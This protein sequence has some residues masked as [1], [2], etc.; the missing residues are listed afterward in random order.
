MSA[1]LKFIHGGV[2]A[3]IQ[4]LPVLAVGPIVVMVNPVTIPFKNILQSAFDGNTYI[5]NMTN[6][7]LHHIATKN[8]PANVAARQITPPSPVQPDVTCTIGSPQSSIKRRLSRKAGIRCLRTLAKEDELRQ[9]AEA[10]GLL[11]L[12]QWTNFAFVEY[13]GATAIEEM[14]ADDAIDMQEARLS[15]EKDMMSRNVDQVTDLLTE[16]LADLSLEDTYDNDED[17]AITDLSNILSHMSLE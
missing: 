13:R 6:V 14:M 2:K 1:M 10:L 5:Y 16:A 7:L 11:V 9:E 12:A 15:K 3:A 4:A 17:A 8:S